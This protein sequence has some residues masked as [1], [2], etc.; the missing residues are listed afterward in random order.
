ME[1]DNRDFSYLETDF[2]FDGSE[3]K[4]DANGFLRIPGKIMKAGELFY[5]DFTAHISKDELKKAVNSAN[6]VDVTIRHPEDMVSPETY[7]KDT[8]GVTGNNM[9][10]KS[11]DG[12]DWIYGDLI[13]K[14]KEGIDLVKRKKAA[15][16]KINVSSGYY[17]KKY[18]MDAKNAVFKDIVFNHVAIGVGVPRA[19]GA[20]LDS[21]ESEKTTTHNIGVSMKFK[22]TLQKNIDFSLDEM[23]IEY[24]ENHEKLVSAFDSREKKMMDSCQKQMDSLKKSMDEMTGAKEGLEAKV[25]KMEEDKKNYISKDE[26]KEL[27]KVKEKAIRYGV[28]ESFET[29]LEGKKLVLKAA[30]DKSFDDAHVDGAFSTLPEDDA[31]AV[32]KAKS[33]AKLQEA[34]NKAGK[35]NDSQD[36]LP[37]SK[38]DTAKVIQIA[39]GRK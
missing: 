35:S 7:K 31:H 28:K 24:D 36:N 38:L 34:N 29:A 27:E 10:I 8:V 1:L 37:L 23:E 5:G 25:K 11:F 12:V 30:Y 4:E 20:S 26:L 15:K 3:L 22:K 9:S 21:K 32:E 33:N 18:S 16:E 2:S 13:I 6:S 14:D 19:D 17:R 39:S